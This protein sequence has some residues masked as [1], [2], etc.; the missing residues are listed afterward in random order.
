VTSKEHDEAAGSVGAASVADAESP[1]AK[2]VV[3]PLLGRCGTCARFARP[4]EVVDRKGVTRRAGECLLEI[5]PAPLYENNTCDRYVQKGTFAATAKS[6]ARRVPTSR[7]GA[8]RG[9]TEEPAYDL[10]FAMPEDLLQMDEKEF[11][12]ALRTVLREE[13][14]MADAELLPRFRGGELVIKPGK[15]GTQEKRIPLDTFF[16]KIVMVRD[17]LRLLEQKV[18]SHPKLEIDEK[19]QMQQY[20]TQA[21]GSL[22]TFNVLFEHREDAFSG[23]KSDE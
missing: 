5:W 3:D 11:R 15:E 20:I 19:V 7:S 1:A 4:I 18:N 9:S 6:R 8:S 17:K 2:P 12:N 21:Y 13:L 10:S 23:Q 14:G 16:H 22:T